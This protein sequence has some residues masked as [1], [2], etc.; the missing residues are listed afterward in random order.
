MA[1]AAHVLR[2]MA[3]GV[4]KM[5]R[6][7]SFKASIV[8][9][10]A[11]LASAFGF[12][13]TAKGTYV[14]FVWRGRE[15]IDILGLGRNFFEVRASNEQSALSLI[16]KRIFSHLQPGDRLTVCVVGSNIRWDFRVGEF[17]D[18]IAED[19]V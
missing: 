8:G 17:G 15:Y 16:T 19:M 4:I 10:L 6:R 14:I 1:N 13:E 11:P 7:T 5:N 2:C 18:V 12:A 9:M 3:L